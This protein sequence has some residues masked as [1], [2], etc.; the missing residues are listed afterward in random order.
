MLFSGFSS[1]LRALCPQP[2][3]HGFSLSCMHMSKQVICARMPTVL[4]DSL[5][6]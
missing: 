6:H 4:W 2:R 3:G 5:K 1:P